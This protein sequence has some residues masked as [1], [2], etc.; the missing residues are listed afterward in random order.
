MIERNRLDLIIFIISEANF[1][2]ILILT[3]VYF[4]RKRPQTEQIFKVLSMASH[5]NH[6]RR[7]VSHW[8]GYRVV[9]PDRQ[10]R[11]N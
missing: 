9:G 10:E 11:D 7:G 8:A 3:Y 1:S 2:L 6:T 5:Y 4:L